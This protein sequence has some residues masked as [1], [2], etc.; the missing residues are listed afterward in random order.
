MKGRTK[1]TLE[2]DDKTTK[3]LHELVRQAGAANRAEVIRNALRVYGALLE[4]EEKGGETVV[5]RKG[6][7]PMLLKLI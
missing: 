3:R 6:G 1:I 2:M 7:P 4:I 5:Q